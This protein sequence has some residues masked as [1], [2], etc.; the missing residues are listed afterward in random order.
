MALAN[1]PQNV[2]LEKNDVAQENEHMTGTEKNDNKNVALK[3]LSTYKTWPSTKWD[4]YLITLIVPQLY[5]ANVAL[6]CFKM[7]L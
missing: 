1:V 5:L 6:H 3:R 2:A 7:S 4:Y